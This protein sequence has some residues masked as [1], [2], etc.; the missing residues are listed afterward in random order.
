MQAAVSVGKAV[1][2]ASFFFFSFLVIIFS[3]LNS[4]A[5]CFGKKNH[6]PFCCSSESSL[7]RGSVTEAC[8][9]AWA[10][11]RQETLVDSLQT[12]LQTG[13]AEAC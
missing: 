5:L 6:V 13:A 12:P 8:Q 2:T 10:A 11:W 7:A 1:K 9:S 4:I 3:L